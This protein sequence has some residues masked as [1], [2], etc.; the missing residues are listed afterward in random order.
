MAARLL[1]AVPGGGESSDSD[2]N[3]D[4]GDFRHL[5]ENTNKHL[6]SQSN[7]DLLKN[8]LTAGN[9]KL[10][11]ELLNSGLSVEC[12]FQFGWTP[13]MYAASISN[14]ETVRI[15]LDRGANANYERDKFSVL[16]AACTSHAA[17][18][19][20]QKCVELLLSRNVD[21]NACCRKKLT[22][23]M[24]ASREGYTK[25]VTLLIAHGADINAQDVNGFTALT[26]AAY[27]GRKN[28]VLKLLELG[29]DKKITT[30]SGDTPAEVA[31]KNNHLAI[32]SILSFAG[33]GNQGF[34][35]SKEESLFRY[36]KATCGSS[37]NH[38]LSC[39]ASSDLEV[40]LHGLG[41]GHLSDTFL[42]CD[43]TLKQL[44]F[45]EEGDLKKAG[46]TDTEDCTKIISAL[47]EIQS[48]E[49]K[50]ESPTFSNTE[51]STDELFAFL[52]KLNRQCI[53]LTHLVETINNQ[54][55]SNPQKYW[56]GTRLKTS[57]QCAKTLWQ[58]PEIS[59]KNCADFGIC[60]ISFRRTK[61]AIHAVCPH[62]KNN[63]VGSGANSYGG[64]H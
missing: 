58:V 22:A 4:M 59:A 25:V 48:E 50:L 64:P 23:L 46:V 2:D 33:N 3:W 47:K 20:I 18:E 19:N 5:T 49:T 35:L 16:M 21:T 56:N 13:L 12:C 60:Y 6:V 14:V 62:G 9:V 30:I 1:H 10:V 32:F 57:L 11:E 55:P 38:T 27:D 15:L 39:S 31:K 43:I 26:W 40:F 36:L 29:A 17:E 34:N 51:S 52:L 37:P 45:L 8:A 24:L 63:K 28:T 61:R 41:L 44:L 53:S 42:D 7:E 54:I